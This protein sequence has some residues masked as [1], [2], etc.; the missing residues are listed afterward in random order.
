MAVLNNQSFS[1]IELLSFKK[2]NIDLL[3]NIEI[4]NI[5]KLGYNR[6]YYMDQYCNL[7]DRALLRGL[8]RRALNFYTECHHILPTCCGGLNED[9]NYVLLTGLEHIIAHILL[10]YIDP[11]NIKLAT[12][13]SFMTSSS[14]YDGIKRDIIKIIEDF[15]IDLL[16]Y[17][18]KLR[19]KCNSNSVICCGENK[20]ILKIY[21]KMIDLKEDGFS[22]VT[23]RRAI[24]ANNR[25]SKGYYWY[26]LSTWT[27]EEELQKIEDYYNKS[28]D[29]DFSPELDIYKIIAYTDDNTIVRIYSNYNDELFKKDG[30]KSNSV[31]S[32]INRENNFY[33]GYYWCRYR[34]W[35]GDKNEI[36]KYYSLKD[37]PKLNNLQ[38]PKFIPQKII[39]C[40]KDYNIIRIYNN[41]H[42]TKID[43][44]N[45]QSISRIFSKNQI[46]FKGYYW[47]KFDEFIKK[48]EEKI[49]EFYNRENSIEVKPDIKET[50]IVCLDTNSNIIKIYNN[51][52]E[53]RVDGFVRESVSTAIR[54]NK[55]YRGYYWKNFSDYLLTNSEDIDIYYNNKHDNFSIKIE[56]WR[57]VCIDP[58]TNKIIK[59]YIN[60]K[61]LREN[62]FVF[63]SILRAIK[64]NR[65]YRGYYWM[66]FSDFK[67][68]YPDKLEEYYKQQEQK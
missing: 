60:S 59:L 32:V 46:K 17:F 15:D 11:N 54:N 58:S 56:L 40:D 33:R 16:R 19:S 4:L 36:S 22:V 55:F 51:K 26:D 24:N 12:A 7:I 13:V 47:Y 39:R 2:L 14:G 53:L 48:H 1:N 42:D 49:N 52:N 21:H 63:E 20:E 67:E 65:L 34:D 27:S 66:K 61:E 45:F 62:N 29:M 9:N 30:I 37:L 8:N 68:K 31:F 57:Y 10:H 43:G 28:M 6:D 35:K 3:E 25:L 5:I 41:Y 23:V 50:R 18:G 38:D 64:I 44:Y